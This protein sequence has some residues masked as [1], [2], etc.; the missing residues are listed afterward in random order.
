M[1]K[2]LAAL[3]IFF[4]IWP[5]FL[6]NLTFVSFNP[7]RSSITSICPSQIFEDPIPIVGILSFFDMFLKILFSFFFEVIKAPESDT[8]FGQVEHKR[9]TTITGRQSRKGQFLSKVFG[10]TDESYSD[11]NA[12]QNT[13]VQQR[14]YEKNRLGKTEDVRDLQK[15][16]VLDKPI[17]KPREV[18]TKGDTNNAGSSFYGDE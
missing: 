7:I 12:V 6:T 3:E 1:L 5:N 4:F 9:F 14:G 11:E 15:S 16:G 18:S 13:F 2:F 10:P 8:I 17:S